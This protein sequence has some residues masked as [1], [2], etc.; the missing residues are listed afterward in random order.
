MSI[1]DGKHVQHTLRTRRQTTQMRIYRS[2]LAFSLPSHL[3]RS[4]FFSFYFDFC[5]WWDKRS[6]LAISNKLGCDQKMQRNQKNVFFSVAV[7]TRIRVFIS[8]LLALRSLLYT[9][10]RKSHRNVE[11][12]ELLSALNGCAMRMDIPFL[13]W[14]LSKHTNCII[15]FL[16]QSEDDNDDGEHTQKPKKYI[17][18]DDW[19]IFCFVCWTSLH[20]YFYVLFFIKKQNL[21]YFFFFRLFPG[22]Y[23]RNDK[24]FAY[25]IRFMRRRHEIHW[26]SEK[27]ACDDHTEFEI[28]SLNPTATAHCS[29]TNKNSF[30]SNAE[31]A[32]AICNMRAES[33]K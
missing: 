11:I 17:N 14:S 32:I 29:K 23:H 28:E 13:L 24:I 10:E 30:E 12:V 1:I 7:S 21:I 25:F 20:I 33:Q 3:F 5:W 2:S 31:T 4:I 9:V 8:L 26:V 22:M 27:R 19:N 18:G 6:L 16:N 15:Y